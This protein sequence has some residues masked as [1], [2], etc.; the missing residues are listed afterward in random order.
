MSF[1]GYVGVPILIPDD[2]TKK[3]W[4]C[5]LLQAVWFLNTKSKYSGKK[6][7]YDVERAPCPSPMFDFL[8]GCNDMSA[9]Q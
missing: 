8:R 4:R 7:W 1:S 5:F 3:G 6:N 9:A 2:V